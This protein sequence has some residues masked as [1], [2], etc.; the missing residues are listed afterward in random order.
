MKALTLALGVALAAPAIVLAAGGSTA[1]TPELSPEQ[2]AIEDYN[3]G[4]KLNQEGRELLERAAAAEDGKERDK[5]L[6][7]AEKAFSKAS[8]RF[9]SAISA[10][11]DLYQA[12]T[13][14]G[15]A[16]RK[17]GD[18]EQAVA[19]YDRALAINPGYGEAIEYRGEAYLHLDQL[20]A[21]KDAYM[22]LFR[23]DREHASMLMEAMRGWVEDRRESGSVDAAMI[24]AFEAWIAERGEAS[25]QVGDPEFH[26]ARRW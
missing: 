12:H 18:Y 8:R 9:E 3:S 10:K 5:L 11:D 1:V 14:L 24:D 21:A 17:L 26:I 19:A 2:E 22:Q 16:L 4:L 25:A 6:A 20:E 15:Y 7:K 23:D 13:S